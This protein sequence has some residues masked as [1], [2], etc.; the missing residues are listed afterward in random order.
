MKAKDIR[1][2]S[3]DELRTQERDLHQEIFQ[4]NFQRH[5]GQLEKHGKIRIAKKDLARLKTILHE[6]TKGG[7]GL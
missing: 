2:L 5:T 6:K 7:V 3:M 4:L 1:E